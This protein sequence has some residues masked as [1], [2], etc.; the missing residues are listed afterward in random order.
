MIKD[1]IIAPNESSLFPAGI[2]DYTHVS[3]VISGR[4]ELASYLGRP[5]VA[6]V[7]HPGM[8]LFIPKETVAE[9]VSRSLNLLWNLWPIFVINLVF[10]CLAGIIYFCLV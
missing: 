4:T 6:A 3:F 8:I 10:I 1:E 5:Y 9:Q 7:D 2:D